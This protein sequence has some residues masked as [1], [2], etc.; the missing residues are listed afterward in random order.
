MRNKILAIAL[1]MLCLF[2][3][4]ASAI[5][6]DTLSSMS[7]G[8]FNGWFYDRDVQG[9]NFFKN[10]EIVKNNWINENEKVYYAKADGVIAK[11]WYQINNN[12]Y[13]FSSTGTLKT[14]WLKDGSNWYYL[15]SDG[16]MAHDTYIGNYYLGTNGAWV[17]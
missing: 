14:G 4:S 10:G 1:C 6:K 11:S 9:Y 13:Y 8:K 7:K 16:T 12:W 15:N 3:I 5:N 17:Q 2:P